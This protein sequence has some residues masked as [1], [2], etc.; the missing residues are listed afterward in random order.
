MR[1]IALDAVVGL[2]ICGHCFP[3]KLTA[4]DTMVALVICGNLF[5]LRLVAVDLWKPLFNVDTD[6]Q[7]D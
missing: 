2:V 4:V 5:S 7:S 6:F 3:G 1:L